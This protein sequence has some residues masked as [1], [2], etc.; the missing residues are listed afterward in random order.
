MKKVL[1]ICV[2]NGGKSQ[3]AAALLRKHAGDWIEVHSAGTHPGST[4]NEESVAA[5]AEV[6]ADMSQETPKPIDPLLLL[7]ADR[8]I[9]LGKQA[10]VAGTV[11]L[12]DTI[13]PSH[14]GITGMERMRLLREDIDN[15]VRTLAEELKQA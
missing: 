4:L 3:M 11:E 5:I 9:V 12:W 13:E 7:N 8:V 10:Q 1:F 2:S 14:D 15:R 6:G